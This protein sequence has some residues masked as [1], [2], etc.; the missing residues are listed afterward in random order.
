M[1]DNVSS[2]EEYRKQRKRKKR[3]KH[4]VIGL[5]IGLLVVTIVL[6]ALFLL[7]D[8]AFGGETDPELIVDTASIDNGISA[9]GY[10]ISVG[11][12]NPL[13]IKKCGNSIFL[14]TK[15]SV[16]AFNQGGEQTHAGHHG[17]SKPMIAASSKRVLTYDQGG[18]QFRIDSNKNRIGAKKLTEK[19]V[20]GTVSDGGYVA[21][22]T[23]TERYTIK[24]T[25]Y[26]PSLDEVLTWNVSDQVITGI[27]FNKSSTACAVTTY[28]AEKGASHSKVYELGFK[29]S[30]AERF[31][32]VLPDCMALSVQYLSNG[33]ISVVGDQKTF[34][35][36]ENGEIKAEWE[37][38]GTLSAF[39]NE[40]EN[41]TILF[42]QDTGDIDNTIIWEI[43]PDGIKSIT[44][45]TRNK[46]IDAYFDGNRLMILTDNQLL[47]LD[48]E[49]TQSHTA[50]LSG[51]PMQVTGIGNAGYVLTAG[52]L[53]Q[54][55][56]S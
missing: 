27:D 32:T 52:K 21:I 54:I 44:G 29:K 7:R 17:Y 19:I 30:E 55:I 11:G 53:E 9:N 37:Y 35:L 56:T 47:T 48:R 40:S 31:Q 3:T 43:D 50:P 33:N 20:Y 15:N 10:P 13:D 4:V 28:S 1:A 25:V 34:V 6:L 26:D 49:L 22:V 46:V 24:L 42:L 23:Q 39:E 36:S 38:L 2:I 45:N 8:G 14:L 5:V 18:Y 12:S 41:G 16:I 51:V